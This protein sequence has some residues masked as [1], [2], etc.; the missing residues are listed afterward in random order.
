[1]AD[2][3]TKVEVVLANG[4]RYAARLVGTD[5]KTDLAVMKIDA[6]EALPFVPFGDSDQMSASTPRLR[7]NP[8]ALRALALPSSVP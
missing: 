5:S 8:G 3:A 7:R 2:G 1:M 6:K 4:F